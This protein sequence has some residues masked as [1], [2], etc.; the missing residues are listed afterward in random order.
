MTVPLIRTDRP[1]YRLSTRPR[2]TIAVP[3]R[4]SPYVPGDGLAVGRTT[5][6]YCVPAVSVIGEAKVAVW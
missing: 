2:R 5:N 6:A 3:E 4:V 1:A